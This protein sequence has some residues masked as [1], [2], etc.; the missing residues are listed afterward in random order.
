MALQSVSLKAADI[1]NVTME[2]GLADGSDYTLQA[3]GGVVSL[4]ESVPKGCSARPATVEA[5]H[6]VLQP[7]VFFPFRQGA[8]ILYAWG[9]AHLLVIDAV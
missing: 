8:D 5:A 6:V 7:Y 9:N 2:L 1:T 3:Q 4:T